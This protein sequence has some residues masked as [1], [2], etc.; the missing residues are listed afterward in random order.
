MQE[1]RK[2]KMEVED[3]REGS[4]DWMVREGFF[5]GVTSRTKELDLH[6][7]GGKHS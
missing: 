1:A 6:T 4:L 3:G 5:E 7:L 2:R